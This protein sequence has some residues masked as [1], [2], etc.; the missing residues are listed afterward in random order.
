MNRRLGF[1]LV[2][3]SLI[4]AVLGFVSYRTAPSF[5]FN[6]L[7]TGLIGGAVC[8]IWGLRAIGGNPGKAL[9]LLTLIPLDFV[10]LSQVVTGWFGVAGASADRHGA[11]AVIT[12]MFVLST[13][14]LMRIAYA[15]VFER[16]L[17]PGA[18]ADQAN[19]R[20]KDRLQ[21]VRRA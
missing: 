5:A 1:Q 13:G 16:Q 4:L 14:M 12:V 21:D 19:R 8:L 2:G 15:G 7:L 18:G 9:V 10:L 3:Y 17:P 20:G 6:T 11:A